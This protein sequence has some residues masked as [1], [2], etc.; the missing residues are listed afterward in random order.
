MKLLKEE[1]TKL[2]RNYAELERKYSKLAAASGDKDLGEFS[3]FVSRLAMTVA[4]LYGR[5]IYSDI[6]IRLSD[7]TIPAHKFVLNARSEEWREEVL[8]DINELGTFS[9]CFFSYSSMFYCLLNFR[10]F[11][12]CIYLDWS[13]LETDIGYALLRWIYTDVIE[14]QHDTLALGLLRAAH[15]FQLSGLLG[16]CERALMSSVGVRT[17]VRF[18]CV[19]EEVGASSL[20]EY[21]SGLISTHWDDLTPQDFEHMTSPLLYK[22][23]KAKSMYA[24]MDFYCAS[25]M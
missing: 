8:A 25:E 24:K 19:A 2:Q 13:D 3:S 18:Y 10:R 7:K 12:I 6:T 20:L 4:T 11:R 5:K 21:C 15:S 16:L 22:M 1:Y 14:L 17:C 23:L 9:R